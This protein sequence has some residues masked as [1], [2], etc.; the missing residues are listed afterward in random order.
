MRKRFWKL[1]W[2][3]ALLPG[4]L[5]GFAASGDIFSHRELDHW[6]ADDAPDLVNVAM[7]VGIIYMIIGVF[8][9]VFHMLTLAR[10]AG[11][12]L[13]RRVRRAQRAE[14]ATKLSDVIGT[15]PTAVF[16]TAVVIWVYALGGVEGVAW[17][18][19]FG[20]L[21]LAMFAIATLEPLR[22]RL[23]PKL[24][25]LDLRRLRGRVRRAEAELGEAQRRLEG[26][27]QELAELEEEATADVAG[28]S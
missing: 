5:I 16:A 14:T 9:A 26:A 13:S 28:T 1:R 8:W 2:D 27:K 10:R 12:R 18:I 25:G 17:P 21:L 19:A 3:I 24:R 4:A 6:I 15:L 20:V 23:M 11:E 22:N 7:G